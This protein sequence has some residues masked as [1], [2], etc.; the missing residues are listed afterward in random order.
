MSERQKAGSNLV[1]GVAIMVLGVLT[2]V[3]GI[4]ARAEDKRARTED[5]SQRA[6]LADNFGKLTEALTVRGDLADRE[7]KNRT[8]SDSSQTKLIVQVFT[9][10]KTPEDAKRIFAE[11]NATQQKVKA[12]ARAITASR[13]AHPYPPFPPGTCDDGLPE[14]KKH[15]KKSESSTPAE[16][17][18]TS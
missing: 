12:E 14:K 2:V 6:C 8:L 10:A 7:S 11:F 9:V 3:Q 16:S 18:Y 17:K 15:E 13:K 1:L 4:Q 5:A